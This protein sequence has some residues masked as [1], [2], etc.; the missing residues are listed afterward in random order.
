MLK[1]TWM[2]SLLMDITGIS[3]AHSA[4]STDKYGSHTLSNSLK[5]GFY[6]KK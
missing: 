4:Q 2:L 6:I 1:F 3:D 5:K